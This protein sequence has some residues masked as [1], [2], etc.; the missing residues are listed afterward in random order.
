MKVVGNDLRWF[1]QHSAFVQD[2]SESLPWVAA[3][4]VEGASEI[5][6]QLGT[7]EKRDYNVRLH[8]MEPETNNAKREFD[9]FLQ[10][11][12]VLSRFNI[13]EQA[14]ARCVLLCG[15]SN[16]LLRTAKFAFASS[17]MKAAP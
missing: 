11:R 1:N 5:A 17:P 10:D 3:S 7:K 13:S 12:E 6:L 2:N 9:V 14:K 16:R 8:F 15:N 4:G